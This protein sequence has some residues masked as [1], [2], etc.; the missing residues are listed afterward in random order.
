MPRTLS[1]KEIE[2]FLKEMVKESSD[3]RKLKLV[4]LG[5][6]RI[7]KTTTIDAITK[8]IHKTDSQ[9]SGVFNNINIAVYFL[10]NIQIEIT[11]TVGIDCTKIKL[12]G[13]EISV[14]DFGGQLEYTATHQFFLSSEVRGI[15]N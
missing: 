5:N 10:N 2:P 15:T 3:W 1:I 12:A 13:G 6:G 7:G 14:W 8:L 4:V 9:V 11:S